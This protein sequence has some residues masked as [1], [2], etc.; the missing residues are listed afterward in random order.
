MVLVVVVMVLVVL[1]VMVVVL[2]VMVVWC[3]VDKISPNGIP[4]DNL[5]TLLTP[6]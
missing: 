1:V 4:G 3:G 2:V 6:S 5:P